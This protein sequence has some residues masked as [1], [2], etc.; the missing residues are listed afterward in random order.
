M[1]ERQRALEEGGWRSAKQRTRV[2]SWRRLM[3]T[4]MYQA[5]RVGFG[6]KVCADEWCSKLTHWPTCRSTTVCGCLHSTNTSCLQY[7]NFTSGTKPCTLR[8]LH[9]YTSRACWFL[10]SYIC[11]SGCGTQHRAT[12]RAYTPIRACSPGSQR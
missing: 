12:W 9:G 4:K 8:T 7:A 1:A 11:C 2:K 3:W 5:D 10:H 6:T